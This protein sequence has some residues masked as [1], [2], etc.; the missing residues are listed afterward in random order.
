[1]RKRQKGLRVSVV[2][3]SR[4]VCKILI[5]NFLVW[6]PKIVNDIQAMLHVLIFQ[7]HDTPVVIT[8]E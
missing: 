3:H 4:P 7:T 6:S 2:L 1:M 5:L 8:T